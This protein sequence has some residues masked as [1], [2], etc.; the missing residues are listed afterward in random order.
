R[1]PIVSEAGQR[2]PYRLRW[3]WEPV[4]R[5]ALGTAQ[6][7]RTALPPLKGT[8]QSTLAD[9]PP[10]IP[11]SLPSVLR[12]SQ[13][14]IDGWGST[15][16]WSC[17][18]R[19]HFKRRFYFPRFHFLKKGHGLMANPLQRTVVGKVVSQLKQWQDQ[20]IVVGQAVQGPQALA[21]LRPAFRF[22]QF[23]QGELQVVRLIPA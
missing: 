15:Y 6:S 5:R 10:G 18:V 19:R 7:P 14:W 21:H 23:T 13:G 17:G 4:A 2:R 11:R 3:P 22:T 20:Q 9:R 8:R 12:H 16:S 1:T